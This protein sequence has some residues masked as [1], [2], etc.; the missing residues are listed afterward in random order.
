METDQ[1]KQTRL[2]AKYGALASFFPPSPDFAL[3]IGR[4]ID[5]SSAGL[6]LQYFA[7]ERPAHVANKLEIFGVYQPLMHVEGIP[8]RIVYDFEVKSNTRSSLKE[9]RCGVAF[10]PLTRSKRL[11]VERFI[12]QYALGLQ[13]KP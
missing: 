1:R 10:G 6:A 4:L 13:E 2:R 5:I 12:E 7:K 9:R 11:Q 3:V 8:G